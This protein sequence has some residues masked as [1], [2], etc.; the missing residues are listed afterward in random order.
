MKTSINIYSD[1]KGEIKRFLELYYS[2]N[3][4]N[5][6]DYLYYKIEFENPIEMINIISCL[7]DNNEKFLL[8]IWISLDSDTYICITDNNINDIIKYIYERYPN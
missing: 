1:F 7:V 5:L 6:S 3:Q 8:T 2:K 4:D